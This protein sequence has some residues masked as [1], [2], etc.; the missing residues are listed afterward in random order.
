LGLLVS[1]SDTET[2][3]NLYLEKGK[4]CVHDLKGMFAFAICDLRNNDPHLFLAR[5]HFGVK[6]L[7]YC[8]Q[9]RKFAFA[10]EIKALLEL[11]D[12]PRELDFESLHQYLTFLWVPDPRTMFK[13]I[14]K[15]PA[16]HSAVFRKGNLEITR[17]WDLVFPKAGHHFSISEEDAAREVRERFTKTVKRQMISDVPVGAVL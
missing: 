3:L 12:C 16:G 10:S 8:H 15:L 6:P 7:Y 1:R 11:P 9:G 5:D 4:E 13:G 14:F 2:I 17:Y